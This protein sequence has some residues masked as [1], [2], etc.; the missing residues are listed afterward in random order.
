M[1]RIGVLALQ[2]A[3]QEHVIATRRAFDSLGIKGEVTRV[4][5]PRNLEHVDALIIPGGESTVIGRL[6]ER[7]GLLERIRERATDQNLAIMGTCAGMVLLAKEVDERH[8]GEVSQPLLRL[9]DISVT[10]N[11]FGRQKES[12]ETF[13]E[14]PVIGPEPF[15]AVFIRAPAVKRILS[16]KVEVLAKL[17]EVPVAVRQENMLA[18]SFHPELTDDLRLHK[19]F[20][21]MTTGV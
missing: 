12:F 18:L 16:N 17:G 4:K 13:L 2:G 8:V 15:R 10:R 6:A 5:L 19:Y 11:A 20:I 1:I 3:V 7:S 21:E 9:M 14:I